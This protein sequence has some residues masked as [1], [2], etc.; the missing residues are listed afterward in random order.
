MM[1]VHRNGENIVS[2][3]VTEK[4]PKQPAESLF[5]ILMGESERNLAEDGGGL[6]DEEVTGASSKT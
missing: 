6:S 3:K 5:S 1:V 4:A 2:D